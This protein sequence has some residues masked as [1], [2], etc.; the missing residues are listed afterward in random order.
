MGDEPER[1]LWRES[2]GDHLFS[3]RNNLRLPRFVSDKPGPLD[4]VDFC[5]EDRLCL[6]VVAV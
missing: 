1:A 5:F 3:A 2:P 6:L 4:P